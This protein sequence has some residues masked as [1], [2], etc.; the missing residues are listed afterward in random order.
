MVVRVSGVLRRTVA[1]G[2]G[3]FDK[4][5]IF[6]ESQIEG[7]GWL[8]APQ[9]PP[10]FCYSLV[11]HIY[12]RLIRQRNDFTAACYRSPFLIRLHVSRSYWPTHYLTACCKNKIQLLPGYCHLLVFQYRN[13]RLKDNTETGYE[14]WTRN[15]ENQFDTI[16]KG[17]L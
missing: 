6:T 11:H 12:L 7:W 3:P 9:R 14:A 8:L 16:F 4:D 13:E 1:G 2:I 15:S 17:C 5:V 10:L